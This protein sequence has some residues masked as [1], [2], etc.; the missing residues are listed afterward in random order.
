M[1]PCTAQLRYRPVGDGP[2]RLNM[3]AQLI[4]AAQC[5]LASGRRSPLGLSKPLRYSCD[6]LEN[7]E[8]RKY[9]KS[10]PI[11]PITDGMHVSV[12][13]IAYYKILSS[14]NRI[15]LPPSVAMPW[16][17]GMHG[18]LVIRQR[19]VPRLAATTGQRVASPLDVPESAESPRSTSHV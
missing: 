11:S 18:K 3:F 7:A 1:D 14:E 17:H 16:S 9:L 4:V 15:V 6:V 19:Q 8:V 12:L 13:P 5:A 10:S 2:A